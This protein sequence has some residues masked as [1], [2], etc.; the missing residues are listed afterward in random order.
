MCIRDSD[1]APNKA[2]YYFGNVTESRVEMMLGRDF[3]LKGYDQG[4]I[5]LFIY[6]IMEINDQTSSSFSKSFQYKEI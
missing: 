4:I 2:E 6:P 3:I 1:K 5:N